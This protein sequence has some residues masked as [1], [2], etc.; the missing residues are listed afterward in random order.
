MSNETFTCVL[1]ALLGLGV[2]GFV[3]ATYNQV[4]R[5]SNLIP[6]AAANV[7]VVLRRR[8]DL[9]GKL[10]AIVESYGIHES[11]LVRAVAGDFGAGGRS[12]TPGAVVERLASLRMSFPALRAD[13]LYDSLM[14]ELA[15]AETQVAQRREHYNA[16]VR[17]YNTLLSQFPNNLLLRPFGF[18]REPFLSD[19]HLASA[20]QPD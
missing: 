5:L 14:L 10:V 20:Q 8:D 17:S 19:A 2:A 4:Q 6:E 12:G 3:V 7:A 13:R 11:S 18:R 16:A 1:L 9:I 15:G